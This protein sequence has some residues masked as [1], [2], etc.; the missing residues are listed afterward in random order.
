MSVAKSII[1]LDL[2]KL[3]VNKEVKIHFLKVWPLFG[4]FC[5]KLAADLSS[6]STFYL[7]IFD[8]CGRIIGQLAT[9]LR[10]SEEV[11]GRTSTLSI[12]LC[13][14]ASRLLGTDSA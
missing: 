1:F 9:L 7:A 8:L 5:T 3:R 10:N 4:P 2:P 12:T 11:K 6:R 14:H 13:T